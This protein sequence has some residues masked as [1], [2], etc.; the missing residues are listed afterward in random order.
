MELVACNTHTPTHTI[1]LIVNVYVHMVCG[2]LHIGSH[3][4]QHCLIEDNVSESV[5]E[6]MY[7]NVVYSLTEYTHTLYVLF[8]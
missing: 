5:H 8:H 3:I 2:E 1:H 7:I 4:D 6:C